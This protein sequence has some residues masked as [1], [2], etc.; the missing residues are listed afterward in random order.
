MVYEGP[1]RG[2]QTCR[3]RHV[4]ASGSASVNKIPNG[5]DLYSAMELAPIAR[6]ASSETKHA[7]DT[8]ATSILRTRIKT[9][10][11]RRERD[12]S[13]RHERKGEREVV[14]QPTPQR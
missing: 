3:D 12:A 7:L 13:R 14:C 5:P 9:R 2:G 4:K 8:R 11:Y 1:S 10:A 6:I